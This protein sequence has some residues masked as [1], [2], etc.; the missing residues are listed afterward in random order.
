MVLHFWGL[1]H[2]KAILM[3]FNETDFNNSLNFQPGPAQPD[4]QPDPDE[5]KEDEEEVEDPSR[6]REPEQ[7]EP[8]IKEPPKSLSKFTCLPTHYSQSPF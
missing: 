6:I 7:K 1:I 2:F 3:K 5:K 8:P 4:V